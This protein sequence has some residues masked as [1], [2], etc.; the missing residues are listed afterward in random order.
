LIPRIY[1]RSS[2]FYHRTVAEIVTSFDGFVAK[3]I[4]DGVLV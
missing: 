4:G 3:Y 2:A 1:A